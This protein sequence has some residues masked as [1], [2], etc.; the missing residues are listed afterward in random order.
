MNFKKL[1]FWVEIFF[2]GLNNVLASGDMN[3]DKNF[4][5]I[6]L[7]YADTCKHCE[8]ERELLM[9]LEERYKN[10]RI[11]EYE[12]TEDD[13]AHLLEEVAELK[14]TIV[15]GVP[16]TIIGDTVYKGYNLELSKPRFMATIEYY[17]NYGYE[18][19]VGEF[20]GNIEVPEVSS[21]KDKPSID[22]YI[23]D[24]INY[25][26]DFPL[27]GEVNAK[28]K[29]IS[30]VVILMGLSFGMKSYS[31][32][33]WLFLIGIFLSRIKSENKVKVGITFLVISIF[34]NIFLI[35]TGINLEKWSIFMD[36][37]RIIVGTGLIGF[38]I[39]RILIYFNRNKIKDTLNSKIN[40][41]KISMV[42]SGLKIIGIVL[43]CFMIN[44]L[45]I[46]NASYVNKMFLEYL[47]INNLT[48]LTKIA[49][50]ILYVIMGVFIDI[51]IFFVG[52]KFLGKN[53]NVVIKK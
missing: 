33:G 15:T 52:V 41:K 3:L 44:L 17:L 19:I 40:S 47:S 50:M 13:N 22:K 14:G 21:I 28:D 18:D 20:I 4:V 37:I 49:Y 42:E 23:D 6:Y 9:E 7:F 25:K 51:G 32:L 27:V 34:T 45:K 39:M 12:I 46:D 10:I 2:I 43:L 35:M 8:A 29:I 38:I 16:F 53:R 48:I 1:C 11:Y 5:N 24:Y 30:V 36:V 31:V 26:I